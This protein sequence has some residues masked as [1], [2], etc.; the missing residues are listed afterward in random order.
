[1]LKQE[2]I[3][4]VSDLLKIDQKILEDAIKDEKEVDLTLDPKLISYTEDEVSTLKTNTYNDGKKA[5][6]EM[7]VKSF[8]EKMGLDFQG[9]TLQGLMDAY[10]KK[11]QADSGKEPNEKIQELTEKI[12][13][14]QNTVKEYETKITEK[15]GLISGL[16]INGELHK[17]IPSLKTEDGPDLNPG[18]VIQLM[19]GSGYDFKMEEGVLVVYREGKKM[20]DKLSNDLKPKEAID[21][22]LKVKKLISVD[23]ANPGG[24]KVISGGGPAL[25]YSKLSDLKKDFEA[26]GKSVMGEEFQKSVEKAVAE[27]KEFDM[28]N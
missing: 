7:E 6:I 14:L 9:K 10:E 2:Q 3:K 18:D 11:I 4:V 13:N 21:E 22:F 20:Q 19:K 24:R 15:E 28:S 25:K 16:Q 26:Q 27:N 5:G 12:T 1:M 8:K 17:H 23:P